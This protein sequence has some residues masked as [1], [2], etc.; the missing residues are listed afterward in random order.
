MKNK[1]HPSTGQACKQRAT[2][3]F[4]SLP[5]I[6]FSDT[7]R[8]GDPMTLGHICYD[9]TL[10]CVYVC[11]K[12]KRNRWCSMIDQF[13]AIAATGLD[14]RMTAD[15]I[16]LPPQQLPTIK[17]HLALCRS[18]RFLRGFCRLSRSVLSWNCNVC[19]DFFFLCSDIHY[20]SSKCCWF[21][22]FSL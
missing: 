21:Q 13:K 3:H 9:M 15:S 7:H 10:V 5:G 11:V 20:L 4:I 16:L 14:Q 19:A 18:E 8:F 12:V 22:N 2:V 17:Q 1:V 6:R